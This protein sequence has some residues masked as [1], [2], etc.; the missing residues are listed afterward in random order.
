MARQL[1]STEIAKD[2]IK[3]ARKARDNARDVDWT[4]AVALGQIV[5]SLIQIRWE[6]V[7]LRGLLSTELSKVR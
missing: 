6:M 1:T 7:E 4:A 5:D 2:E 3:T